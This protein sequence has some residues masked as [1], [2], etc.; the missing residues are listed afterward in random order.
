MSSQNIPLKGRTGFQESSR[1]LATEAIRVWAAEWGIRSSGRA[2]GLSRA[3]LRDVVIELRIAE[4]AGI[5]AI[6]ISTAPRRN[7]VRLEIPA[8]AESVSKRTSWA[9]CVNLA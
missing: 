5:A 7:V 3:F 6:F 9:R 1:I 4:M 2:P 8:L